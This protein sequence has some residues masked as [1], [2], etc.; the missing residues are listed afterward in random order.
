MPSYASLYMVNGMAEMRAAAEKVQRYLSQVAQTN[1]N[2]EWIHKLTKV[3]RANIGVMFYLNQPVSYLNKP[4]DKWA[5]DVASKE[6]AKGFNSNLANKIS[7]IIE[8]P[9]DFKISSVNNSFLNGH[10]DYS[11]LVNEKT[12]LKPEQLQKLNEVLDVTVE[13]SAKYKAEI[14]T[15]NSMFITSLDVFYESTNSISKSITSLHNAIKAGQ[16]ESQFLADLKKAVNTCSEA[17]AKGG[18][19][20]KEDFQTFKKFVELM[21]TSQANLSKIIENIIK[22]NN[23]PY[24][25]RENSEKIKEVAGKMLRR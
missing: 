21:K 7:N 4:L 10:Y 12:K 18:K 16:D 6:I 8:Y 17:I 22:N 15:S 24:E 1:E 19:Q 20:S 13:N 2:P 5:N 14:L 9:L 11:K 3:L 23:M 25:I